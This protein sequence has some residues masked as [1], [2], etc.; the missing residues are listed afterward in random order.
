ML[1]RMNTAQQ[2]QR[3]VAVGSMHDMTALHGGGTPY[4]APQGRQAPAPS[5]RLTEPLRSTDGRGWSKDGP[6]IAI[7]VIARDRVRMRVGPGSPRRPW[8]FDQI[9]GACMGAASRA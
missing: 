2:A 8:I 5:R 1:G 9:A 3:R 7:V 4:R 6:S